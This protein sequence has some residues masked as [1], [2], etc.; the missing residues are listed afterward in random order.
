MN[1]IDFNGKVALVTGATGE[2]GKSI[3]KELGELNARLV[4]TGRDNKKLE[5]IK[6]ELKNDNIQVEPIVAD[7]SRSEDV[8]NLVRKSLEKFGKIDI[9]ICNAAAINDKVFLDLSEEDWDYIIRVNLTSVFILLKEVVPIMI[10]QKY[11]K[12]VIVTSIVGITGGLGK[13]NLAYTAS[14]AGLIGVTKNL[15][16]NLAKYNITV[17]AVAP[18]FILSEMLTKSNITDKYKNLLDLIPVGRFGTPEDVA[19]AV[20]FLASDRSSYITGEILEITGGMI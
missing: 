13:A 10:K 16:K 11:G 2:I 6:E 14:K 9:V 8:K 4:I 1:W 17:N 15:A 3:A 20:V 7:L 5:A 18:S 19:N 12:I